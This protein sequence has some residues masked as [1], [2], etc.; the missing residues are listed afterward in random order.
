MIELGQNI[1]K[2]IGGL[3]SIIIIIILAFT[4]TKIMDLQN[5]TIN[6]LQSSSKQLRQ[7]YHNLEDR[8][9]TITAEVKE[10]NKKLT[11]Y[12]DRSSKSAEYLSAKVSKLDNY[13]D[14]E[15]TVKA[16]PTLVATKA[17][18]AINTYE[19]EFACLTG[20]VSFCSSQ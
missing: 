6:T 14:R 4:T 8:I 13:V 19:D 7:D 20:N 3:P 5:T 9:N 11:L 12:Y 18:R 17:Q 15:D 16:K 1:A 10:N 2:A